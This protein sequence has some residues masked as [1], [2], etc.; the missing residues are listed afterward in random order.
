MSKL[1]TQGVAGAHGGVMKYYGEVQPWQ[2]GLRT[3]IWRRTYIV[4]S[5]FFQHIARAF[6]AIWSEV[7]AI[8]M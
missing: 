7:K 3:I 8:G 1:A 4:A 5:V 2:G 6:W